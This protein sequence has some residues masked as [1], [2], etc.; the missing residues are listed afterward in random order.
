[1]LEVAYEELVAEP[2]PMTRKIAAFCGLKWDPSC[3]Q[4][5]K[6]DGASFT[7]SEIQVRKPLNRDGLERWR[8][9]QAELESLSKLLTDNKLI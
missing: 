7:F 9:Y 6:K 5:E 8:N 3:L 2:E 4:F 1:V